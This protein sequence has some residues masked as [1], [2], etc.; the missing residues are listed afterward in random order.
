[1]SIQLDFIS[2]L[3]VKDKLNY[4]SKTKNI[5]WLYSSK[6]F[7][8]NDETEL[9]AIVEKA[10]A[11]SNP[12]AVD[13]ETTGLLVG[14][15][16]LVGVS[17]SWVEEDGE[18]ISFYVPVL[19]DVDKVKIPPHVTL[20]ILKP[21]LEQPC[22]FFNFR[23]DYKF[24]RS[25]GIEAKC[26]ADVQLMRLFPKG[27]MDDVQFS[28]LK[29]SSLKDSFKEE[30]DLDMLNLEDILGKGIYSFSLAP[31]ELGKLYAAV[32]AFATIKLYN[33][34]LNNI[35]NGFIYDLETRLLPIVAEIEYRGIKIDSESLKKAR[36]EITAENRE[37]EKKIYALAGEPFLISSPQQLGKIL[38]EKLK[39]PV[40][41]MTTE[42]GDTPSTDKFA[43]NK[44]DHPIIEPLLKYK[45]NLKLITAFLGKL[46]SNLSE[47]GH[48]HTHLNPYGAISG[49]FTSDHPN[50][51]Q[52]PKAKED[53]ENSAILR[54]S[55]IADKGYYLLDFDYSMVEYRLL[56][57]MCKDPKLIKMFADGVDV[58]TGTASIMFGVP[59]DKVTKDLRTKGK[60]L[61]FGIIY[62]MGPSGLA[63]QLKC[64]VE[65]A[66]NLLRDYFKAIPGVR[67]WIDNARQDAKIRKC[68]STYYGRIR[69]LPKL[70][71]PETEENKRFIG[72]ALRQA[73]NTTIQGTAAD[74]LKIAMIRLDKALKDKDIHMILQVHDELLFQVNENIPIQEAVDLIKKCMELKIEGF[75]PIVADPAVGY[76]WGN[77]I[78]YEPG[79]TLDNIPV[80][81][82]ITVSGESSLILGKGEELKQLFREFKG[83]HEVYIRMN[84]HEKNYL[85]KPQDTDQETGEI[86]E[87]KVFPNGKLIK[88]IENIGLSVKIN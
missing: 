87:M 49:R 70:A 73:V 85:I 42:D 54:K 48:I 55:F 19:S 18:P 88:N 9:R 60:T 52:V 76:S 15:D 66:K 50:L 24:L 29:S 80:G 7:C 57:S 45:K 16:K 11:C 12:K 31:L 20:S 2:P 35:D 25:V 39:L 3:M 79:M 51:Q 82:K 69:R 72:E 22:V 71:L 53:E 34:Y 37:L 47:D 86:T 63:K 46:A 58:H 6:L 74:I 28:K 77:V 1:M 44:I 14:T 4:I 32:D 38:Y 43:L 23:F 61:N 41:D 65:D 5:N 40:T 17:V 36:E 26:L 81:D 84:D 27:G 78:D 33:K 8:I 10:L 21:L 13:T 68:T 59:V 75:V 62:G 83:E 64:T 30:F 56:A 67:P